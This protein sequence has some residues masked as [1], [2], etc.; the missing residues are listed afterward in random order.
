MAL[1][2]LPSSPLPST[3]WSY[4]PLEESLKKEEKNYH[5]CDSEVSV[6][7]SGDPISI[8]GWGRSPGEG[9]GNPL[10]YS[11]LENPMDGGAWWAAVHGVA[12]SRTRLNDFTFTFFSHE[13]NSH[14]RVG[15]DLM[16]TDSWK[17]QKRSEQTL[18]LEC[19]APKAHEWRIQDPMNVC[20][21]PAENNPWKVSSLEPNVVK[22]NMPS[23]C[24]Y[25]Q[26][27]RKFQPAQRKKK[28]LWKS[29]ESSLL[30][31]KNVC[32]TKNAN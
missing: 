7:N 21:A 12:E 18:T 5:C 9:H 25:L 22:D 3:P 15:T 27:A 29:V 13:C 2:P 26:D 14:I 32:W 1:S 28:A 23:Y 20:A 11:C 31:N 6:Y 24:A 16:E 8:P 30:N 17:R 19:Q 4:F 10:Q